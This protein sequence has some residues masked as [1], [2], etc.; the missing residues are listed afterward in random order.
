MGML[1]KEEKTNP[2]AKRN[3][4]GFT[5]KPMANG[6]FVVGTDTGVGKTIASCALLHAFG[7]NGYKTIGMK[8]VATGVTG[9]ADDDLAHIKSAS[10]VSAEN[11]LVN[12]YAFSEPVAPHIASTL[13]NE[14]IDL[15]RIVQAYNQLTRVADIVIV[16]GIGGFNVPVGKNE[17]MADLAIL[18][19]I[20]IIL[21]V[22]LRLG[23][24]NHALLTN[25]AIKFINIPIVG[26]VASQINPYMLRV[27]ENI[28]TL[29]TRLAAPLLG[30]L[31]YN[32]SVNYRDLS[33]YLDIS[34][35]HPGPK[36]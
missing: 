19:S 6:F 2:R 7:M 22:G 15:S 32:P 30:I 3:R 21:V 36:F 33:K 31:P 27:D 11:H 24:L 9:S 4:L 29:R 34:K 1:G 12:P 20:P 26:W 25:E 10:N 28:Q 23:C 35:L 17:T 14:T 13:Q 8:P 18:L 16:E 5:Q